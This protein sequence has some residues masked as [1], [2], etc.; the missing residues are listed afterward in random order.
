G[1]SEIFIRRPVAT[2]LLML[3]LLMIGL[4]AY[5]LLPVAPLPQIDFPT[6]S[7]SA[8]LPGAS[9]QTMASSVAQ[10]LER[11]FAQIPG[12]SQ[13]TSTSSLGVASITLQFNL[14]RDIDAAA[15][16]VQ[17]AIN[18]A[19]G[20]LPKNLPGPPTYR[21]TNPAD[22]PILILS[23]NSDLEPLVDVDEVAENILAQRMSQIAGVSL[24]RVGGQQ[25]KA[26]RIQIDPAKLVE[27]NLT[28]EDVRSQIM[29]ATVDDP[30]GAIVGDRQ[31][32]TIY[33]NDQITLAKD[34]DN[35]IIAYRNGA[36]V[37][38]RD[39][40]KAVS[41]PADVLQAG[42]AHGKR[43]VFLVVYKE[44]G[45]NVISTVEKIKRQLVKIRTAVP[46]D[47]HV[48]IISDRTT[49]IRA[50]VSDV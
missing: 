34:W 35:V 31:T 48:R 16:D 46:P 5:P 7:V 19:G 18:A 49:T 45:A 20:Q 17:A 15:N 38:V 33:D 47:V 1:F 23:V 26:I 12:V 39:V 3:A 9:P 14:D 42:W 4:V 36:P 41:G 37:R 13:M 2:T 6:I 11:Q 40:G 50:S 22:A 29:S 10:P 43:G 8:Q 25:Q 21:K 28:L 30:K 44:P 24:V 32:Y 27:K